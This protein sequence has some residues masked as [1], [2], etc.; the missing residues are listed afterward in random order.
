[1]FDE[2]CMPYLQKAS[3]KT[4]VSINI[5]MLDF[6]HAPIMIVGEAP[7]AD[8]LGDI[9]DNANPTVA[10][11]AK[12]DGCLIRVTAYAGTRE[13]ALA[14]LSPM[15]EKIRRVLKDEYIASIKEEDQ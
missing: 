5:K 7:V 15:V 4:I 9:L 6:K 8:A 12:E 3:H 10:T 2:Y 13:N 1:M 11:Y 14:L